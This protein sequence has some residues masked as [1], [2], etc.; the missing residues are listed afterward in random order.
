MNTLGALQD[1]IGLALTTK[2]AFLL[3][4][5][6]LLW[7]IGAPM[8]FQRAHAANLTS[9]SDTLTNSNVGTLSGHH[10]QF[11]NA[12]ST[13]GGQTIKIQFDPA[14]NLFT[15][16]FS[17]ATT[18]DI[19]ATGFTVVT[20]ATACS[21][22]A[23]EAYPTGNYNNGSDENLTFT[24]CPTDVIAAG[25]IIIGIGTSTR[26]ITNPSAAGS[27]R[28]FI[29]GTQDNAGETRVAVLQNITLTASVNTSFTFTV[30]GLATTTGFNGNLATTT[31]SSTPTSLPFSTL[32][33]STGAVILG[34]QLA[35]S[36][37]A[38]NGF[39]V[40]VQESAPPTSSTGSTIDL[41]NNG[42]TSSVPIAWTYPT[43]IL[44]VPSTYGHFGITSD[45]DLNSSEFASSTLWAGNID[46]P[47]VVFSHAGP[48]DGSTQF[49]GKARVGFKIQVSDLQEAGFDYT[50]TITY[51]A[52]PT[53]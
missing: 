7:T 21:G 47:R 30:T 20:N 44:D 48:A 38:R 45:D 28:I 15:E 31:A 51:V 5:S 36:T 6:I 25:T 53:F 13:I 39:S 32:A 49:K 14:T 35:V 1:R 43:A 40:T 33:S 8:L 34:Q 4:I 27:Y 23:S 12:T 24:V 26:L 19:T 9:V 17:S 46:L 37:N 11:T 42:A 18:T 50:N 2:V 29:G 16:A 22:A 41:F 3:V 10:I 52:T